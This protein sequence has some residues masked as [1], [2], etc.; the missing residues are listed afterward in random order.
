M[1]SI[2]FCCILHQV[3]ATE[4]ITYQDSERLEI[5]AIASP[6]KDYKASFLVNQALHI[7]LEKSSDIEI[8]VKTK[9]IKKV[10]GR[11]VFKDALTELEYTLVCNKAI[12]GS[13]LTSLKNFDYLLIIKSF[14]EEDDIDTYTLSEKLRNIAEFQAA[15]PTNKLN[16]K[17]EKLLFEI[18]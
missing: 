16:K 11:Y 2:F 17:E 8:D 3:L 1:Q 15:L 7:L 18:I 13:F 9:S 10:F 14:E 12:N 6:V 5:I 4:K